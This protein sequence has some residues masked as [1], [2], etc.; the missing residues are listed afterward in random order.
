MIGPRANNGRPRPAPRTDANKIMSD[1]YDTSRGVS[2]GRAGAVGGPDPR[3]NLTT[4]R[5]TPCPLTNFSLTSTPLARPAEVTG[6]RRMCSRYWTVGFGMPR[7]ESA[8]E[9]REHSG[10]MEQL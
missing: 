9:H 4:D 2:G 6:A 3:A 1:T 10:A 7:N 5:K 8:G